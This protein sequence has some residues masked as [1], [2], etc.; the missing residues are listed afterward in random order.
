LTPAIGII[1]WVSDTIS[2]TDLL[3]SGSQCVHHRYMQLTSQVTGVPQ[4]SMVKCRQ[5]MSDF[6]EESKSIEK[7]LKGDQRAR[8]SMRKQRRSMQ[9]ALYREICRRFAPTM[10]RFF[11]E[12]FPDAHQWFVRRR[13][14]TRSCAVNSIVGYVMGLGDRHSSNILL[15]K[16]T[17]EF[18]HIDFGVAFEAGKRLPTP[19]LVPFRLTRSIV[20]GFGVT[21]VEGVF[22][23]CC[24]QTLRVLRTNA[25]TLMTVLR[26][27]V[28]DP[29]YSWSLSPDR[30]ARLRPREEPPP[31]PISRAASLAADGGSGGGNGKGSSGRCGRKR[32]DD[33]ATAP[34]AVT[35]I[36]ATA[37]LM[38]DG[39]DGYG[40]GEDDGDEHGDGG[41]NAAAKRALFVVRQKLLG[42]DAD[43][44]G[45]GGVGTQLSVRGQVACLLRVAQDP[46]KLAM[47]FSGW[48]SW[49]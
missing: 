1:E 2:I 13:A 23:R 5:T 31:A 19:E 12:Q 14:Y 27:L 30:L 34:A 36:T 17:A 15:D 6:Q 20:D 7:R 35:H 22:R 4:W 42:A 33:A 18:V 28:H 48:A 37:S 3:F 8:L 49:V 44:G 39:G 11:A 41:G 9:R 26:V 16:Q 47:H 40:G 46:D 10:H 32:G 21:G 25:N 43:L 29:L 24:E 38:S 45:G